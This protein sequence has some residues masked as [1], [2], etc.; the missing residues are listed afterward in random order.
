MTSSVPSME[1]A[2]RRRN[3]AVASSSRSFPLFCVNHCILYAEIYNHTE[4]ANYS[5]SRSVLPVVKRR[6]YIA[7]TL[8][9]AILAVTAPSYCRL[10]SSAHN[11]RERFQELS[12]SD[13]GTVQRLVLSLVLANAKTPKTTPSS[14]IPR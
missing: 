10:A 9:A 11:F 13:V 5:P 6:A 4:A 7:A 14:E 1:S 8:M 12:K 2:D 3:F